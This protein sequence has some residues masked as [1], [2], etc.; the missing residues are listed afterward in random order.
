MI[1]QDVQLKE[2]DRRLSDLL[3]SKC[4]VDFLEAI[5]QRVQVLVR[6]GTLNLEREQH[7]VERDHVH[8]NV[9]AERLERQ[10]GGNLMGWNF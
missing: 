10:V 8:Q 4:F 6:D 2:R 5:T 9:I 1:D 7:E 3:L